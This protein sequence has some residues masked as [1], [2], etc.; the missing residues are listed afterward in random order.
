MEIEFQKIAG[1][2]GNPYG[3]MSDAL[4][5]Y[6]LGKEIRVD[7]RQRMNEVGLIKWETQNPNKKQNNEERPMRKEDYRKINTGNYLYRIS[8][9]GKK[10]VRGSVVCVYN[11]AGRPYMTATFN[12]HFQ[13]VQY[14]E[15]GKVI[16]LNRNNA[17]QMRRKM[18]G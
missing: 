5:R 10:I 1:H 8:N 12:G 17:E 15:L 13:D 3:D 4:A 11:K 7:L 9:G 18:Y 2:V 16:F 14:G 6:A